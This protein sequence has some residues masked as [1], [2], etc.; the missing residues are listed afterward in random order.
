MIASKDGID[1]RK[2]NFVHPK[3]ANCAHIAIILSLPIVH[4]FL[5]ILSV[6]IVHILQSS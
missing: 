6:P 3:L 1:K 5:I 2:D 4:I